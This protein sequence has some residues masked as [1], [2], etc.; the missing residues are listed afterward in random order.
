[1]TDIPIKIRIKQE[2]AQKTKEDIDGLSGGVGGSTGVAGLKKA[3]GGLTGDS[4]AISGLSGGAVGIATVAIG[5]EFVAAVKAAKFVIN[6]IIPAIQ[7]F[8][9]ELERQVGIINRTEG[10]VDAAATAVGGLISNID[11]IISRNRLMQSG[12]HLT[13]QQFADVTE[14]ALNF[15][16]ALGTD[17]VGATQQLSE[18]LISLSRESLGKFGIAIDS[19]KTRS[20]Q[21]ADALSQLNAKA[22]EMETGADTLGGVI[23]ELAVAA[24]NAKTEFLEA[25]AANRELLPAWRELEAATR[26]LAQLLNVD[27]VDGLSIST[28]L[29][30]VFAG[31]LEVLIR[32]VSATMRAMTAF[33]EALRTGD[34]GG[35]VEGLRSIVRALQPIGDEAA[36]A[37]Q[38]ILEM[39]QAMRSVMQPIPTATTETPRAGRGRRAPSEESLETLE[40]ARARAVEAQ[41][42]KEVLRLSELIDNLLNAEGEQLDANNFLAEQFSAE[43]NTAL[44][45]LQARLAEENHLNDIRQLDRDNEAA[46]RE[47]R[48]LDEDARKQARIEELAILLQQNAIQTEMAASQENSGTRILE[49]QQQRLT[50]QREMF[51]LTDD[52]RAA[53]FESV[54]PIQ[55]MA[56]EQELL[57]DIIR[58]T[59]VVTSNMDKAL[60]AVAAS[61]QSL[62]SLWN[63]TF[64]LIAQG[65]EDTAK[66]FVRILDAWLTQ[67]AIQEGF[68]SAKEFVEAIASAATF[69]FVA[70]GQHAAAGAGH[71]ALAVAAGG[72]AAAIPNPGQPG[73]GSDNQQREGSRDAGAREPSTIVIN[74]NGQRLLTDAEVGQSVRRALEAES[75]RF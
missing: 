33:N 38:R 68:L 58:R 53:L 25:L 60:E 66:Q 13:D 74:V 43:Q 52:V 51:Q 71:L 62:N 65:G 75:R 72:A 54:F 35:A 67:F 9:N 19:S 40:I 16:T 31:V 49:L 28:Q 17:S 61:A 26:E 46:E 63:Q 3:F 32:R 22:G 6:T 44:L 5:I 56:T 70:A 39:I 18:A 30:A 20:E 15:A 11:L 41:N 7:S 4:G 69:N 50:L 64:D 47:Q 37:T 21:L 23:Q 59:V 24:E 42:I 34:F 55:M 48:R 45:I 2:G 29:G 73:G 12:L 27:L 10:S 8:G 1:M 36:A 57:N 14:V